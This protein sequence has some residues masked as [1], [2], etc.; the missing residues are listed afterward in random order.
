M[1][2][3]QKYERQQ[4]ARMQQQNFTQGGAWDGMYEDEPAP[5]NGNGGRGGF[6]GRGGR[7]GRGGGA[8]TAA[9]PVQAPAGAP[10]GPKNAGR[11]G[12]NYRGGGRGSH[13]GYHPY[14]RGG[15]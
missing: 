10:T 13:R 9:V 3:Q 14:A 6:A 12:S 15:S 7:G 8:G 5:G 11:P 4:M 2:E 1:F